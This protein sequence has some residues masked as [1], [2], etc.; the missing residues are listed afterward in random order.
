M[1][2]TEPS[3]ERVFELF[4]ANQRTAAVKAA[5]ELDLFTAIGEGAATPEALAARCGASARGVRVLADA[6][7]ALGLLGKENG[8]WALAPDAATFLD[9]RSLTYIGSMVL[10]LS[11]PPVMGGFERLT[12]AVRRGATAIGPEGT[13]APEHPVWIEFARHMASP[14][15]LTADLVAG[16]LGAE[17]APP[18][19]ILDVAASHGLYGITL[20]RRNPNARVTALDWANVLA[21]ARENAERAGVA[22]RM[23]YLPGSALEVDLG[24]PYDLIPLPNFLHHFPARECETI[25]RRMHAALAPNGRLAALD[26][27]I[28]EG[29][30][31]PAPSAAFSLVMLATTPAGDVYTHAEYERMFRAAGFVRVERERLPVPQDLLIGYR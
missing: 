11:A 8:R 15:T 22:D 14:A 31:S 6:L 28:D 24:G 7:V 5:V 18:W 3:I 13:L 9:R 17:S 27:V 21:V 30:T 10:F 2:D 23:A 12:E 19:R 4:T 25:L 20:A 29:R 26:F 1:A 16:M